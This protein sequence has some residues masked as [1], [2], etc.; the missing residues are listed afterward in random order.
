[1]LPHPGAARPPHIPHLSKYMISLATDNGYLQ[2]FQEVIYQL[3]EEDWAK[4]FKYV[5][6]LGQPLPPY[7]KTHD[8]SVNY[9]PISTS[10][11]SAIAQQLLVK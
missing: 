4:K 5:T 2:H 7:Y 11:F 6:P 9:K 10:L 8:I 3:C 1:M